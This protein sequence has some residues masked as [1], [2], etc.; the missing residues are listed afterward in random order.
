[1]AD[2]P[3][4][5]GERLDRLREKAA[6]LAARVRIW[7]DK[8]FGFHAAGQIANEND[9]LLMWVNGRTK[10]P[11]SDCSR[12]GGQVH[13][14]SEWRA[15]GIEPQSPDLA[16]GGWHCQCRLVEVPG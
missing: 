10:K 3:Y 16:C 11:C 4:E 14:A 5:L 2:T 15:M 13:R 1:M 8:L 7:R 6:G 12:L 9:P